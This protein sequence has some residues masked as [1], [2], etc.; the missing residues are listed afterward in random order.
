MRPSKLI[1]E[2]AVTA[3]TQISRSVVPLYFLHGTG[4]KCSYLVFAK[5]PK[6]DEAQA[7]GA[8]FVGAE[9]LIPK[10]PERR[11]V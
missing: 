2:P 11:M 3:V 5:G 9:E 1:S 4:K 8:D 6:A 10:N 7:A